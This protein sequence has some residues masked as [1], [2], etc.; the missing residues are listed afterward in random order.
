MKRGKQ[1]TR[2]QKEIVSGH[3]LNVKEWRF[4]KQINESYMQFVN[5]ETGQLKS[6]DIYKKKRRVTYADQKNE[7]D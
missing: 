6:L 5:A 7:C 2:E 1:L 4:V 3:G